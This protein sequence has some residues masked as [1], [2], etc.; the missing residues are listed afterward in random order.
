MLSTLNSNLILLIHIPES[1]STWSSFPLNSNLILLIRRPPERNMDAHL[2][3]NSNLILLIPSMSVHRISPWSPLN[4]NLF[5]HYTVSINPWEDI[6]AILDKKIQR[7][8][9]MLSHASFVSGCGA[10][11]NKDWI[12]DVSGLFLQFPLLIRVI[13]QVR[14]GVP[15][16]S[17]SK[18][19]FQAQL[20]RLKISFFY[21]RT[22]L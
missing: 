5:F 14:K 16:Q 9:A 2:P 21:L 1:G 3:L 8:K 10:D 17:V 4:S 22:Y 11:S 15:L 20:K 19:L 12:S 13:Y 6:S 7:E 18:R